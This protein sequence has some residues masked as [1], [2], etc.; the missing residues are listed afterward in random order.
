MYLFLLPSDCLSMTFQ[1][2][3]LLSRVD[4]CQ[5]E[6]Q[7]TDRAAIVRPLEDTST[8][9]SRDLLEGDLMDIFEGENARAEK[10]RPGSV[11]TS[12]LNVEL[13][14][15]SCAGHSAQLL[16]FFQL[17]HGLKGMWSKVRKCRVIAKMLT[18]RAILQG[19][20]SDD[21]LL[22]GAKSLLMKY[23]LGDSG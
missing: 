1:D 4:A 20:L 23:A 2:R 16:S 18:E 10:L 9:A 8:R 17:V 12:L 21:R 22:S 3:T 15:V 11:G 13:D 6:V 19:V 14:S 7:V 5:V